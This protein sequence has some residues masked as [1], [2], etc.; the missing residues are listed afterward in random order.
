MA[1]LRAVGWTTEAPRRMLVRMTASLWQ[2]GGRLA[3]GVLWGAAWVACGGAR[4]ATVHVAPGG[5]D[6][7]DGS[8]GRPVA[9]LERAR[10]AVRAAAADDGQPRRVALHG[11]TY[12]LARTL[13][14]GPADSGVTWEAV[15]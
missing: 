7:N 3:W 1:E 13:E 10:D 4:A 6:A 15:A 12:V 5:N 11:G 2:V 14:L 9:T 8:A